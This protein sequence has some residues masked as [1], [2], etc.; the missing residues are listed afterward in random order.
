M[1][2]SYFRIRQNLDKAVERLCNWNGSVFKERIETDYSRAVDVS[3]NEKGQWK[4]G[5][6]YAYENEGWTVFE[7]LSGGYSFIEPKQWKEFAGNDELVF[8]AY[9]DAMLYAEMIV[10]EHSTLTKHFVECAD[11]PEENVNEGD[12]VPGIETW[13]DVASFVDADDLVYSDKGVVFIL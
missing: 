8:A 2:P 10:I 13:I 3:L 5:C 7:D 1:N 9:N 4:G 6:L 11:I 12:G